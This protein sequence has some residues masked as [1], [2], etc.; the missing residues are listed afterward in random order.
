V[1]ETHLPNLSA[2]SKYCCRAF[3]YQSPAQTPEV[4]LSHLRQEIEQHGYK[5][6]I[7]MSDV[8]IT[9]I[10]SIQDELQSMVEL[11]IPSIGSLQRS[12]DKAEIY[13][14][15]DSLGIPK[16]Q[17]YAPT[18]EVE[19]KRLIEEIKYPV[20]I[21]PRRSRVMTQKGMYHGLV[22]YAT[23][24]EELLLKYYAIHQY[25]PWP[26][27]QER[28][29]GPGCGVFVL[30][31]RGNP[32]AW[33]AHRRLR[34]KPP[35]GGVSVLRESI[36][37]DPTIQA[38]AK[39]LLQAL[40]WHGVAMVEFKLDAADDYRPKLMEVNGRLG[41]SL[42]LAIDAGVNFPALLY[43]MVTNGDVAPCNDYQVGVRTRWLVGDLDHLLAR[44]L[45]SSRSLQLPSNAPGRFQTLKEFCRFRDPNLHYELFQRDDLRPGFF[46]LAQYVGGMTRHLSRKL[47][48]RLWHKRP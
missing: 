9:Q 41:G 48:E 5:L 12:F 32:R 37:L 2:C 15:A 11:P 7:P 21:R 23:S 4:F 40:D 44:M 3:V 33:F 34:E 29:N 25:I 10:A 43:R 39:R 45:K 36:P 17:T 19:L 42:Q 8:T 13:R 30:M 47:Q 16:P 6:V 26:L 20:V 27:L 14:L 22:D 38:Y 1:G 18:S 28:I 35:S 31:N 24:G 46:D